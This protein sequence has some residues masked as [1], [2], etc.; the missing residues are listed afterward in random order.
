VTGRN[1]VTA[2]LIVGVTIAAYA[3]S[4]R[5]PFLWDDLSEIAD[6]PAIRMLLPFWRPMFT[7][8]ELP[9]R[10]V[11]YLTFALNHA[12]G[13]ML[14]AA[15]LQTDPL[16]TLPFHAVN[17]V[18]HLLN[19]WMLYCVVRDLLSRAPPVSPASGAHARTL[20]CLAV[21]LWLVHPLQ[22][23]AVSY[24]YQR[25]ELLASF[26]A[27]A[28]LAMFLKA[29]AASRP[30]PW[31]VVA[32]IA[33]GIGMACK[34][35]MVVV[36]LVVLL[37][38]RAFLAPSWR[39]AFARRG[40]WHAAL[41]ATIPLALVIVAVQRTRYP[42]A[43]F[44]AWQSFLYAVNQP[45]VILWYLSRLILPL[46]LS[47]DHGGVLRTEP[48]GRDAWLFAPAVLAVAA[49]AWAA[50]RLSRGPAA[51]FMILAFLLLLAPTSSVVPV[52]DPCVEHRMYLAAAI[53]ITAA[54]AA[55]GGRLIATGTSSHILA[56]G[57]PLVLVLAMITADRN[58][59]YC[60][61]VEVWQDAALKNGG[62]SRSLARL[63]SELSKL[64][65][66]AEALHACERAVQRNPSNPVPFAALAAALLNAERP[67]DAAAVCQA[68]LAAAA[69]TAAFTDPVRDRLSMYRGIALDR[70]GD[71]EAEPLLREA[72]ARRPDS[73]V[74]REHLARCLAQKSPR[75]SAA[76][77]AS[78]LAATPGDG[79][80]L[81][82]LGS[83]VARFDPGQAAKI[84]RA[85]VAADPENADACNNLG[86]VLLALGR[87][88]DAV[89]AFESCLRIDPTH[90]QAAANLNAITHPRSS[91][92]ALP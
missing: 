69:S 90:Q 21:S 71:P 68:G 52:L 6:N 70:L 87:R 16:D 54:V 50:F 24:I 67:A 27:L 32:T 12:L 2:A 62:S 29:A 88:D 77:W 72:V 82:H 86:G 37:A 59:V 81:F 11:P 64:D 73:L 20:A 41:F 19:G 43:G 18:I 53:P 48:F 44:T 45:A 13:R 5:G 38:D 47:L 91:A 74:A 34:E 65:R 1:R 31:L 49:A 33:C 76:L 25:I 30:L 35:W 10:P 14:V 3:P 46:G 89:R 60:S 42:E 85:A 80:L 92:P 7:G 8:G 15:G 39:E 83:A 23:Q 22:S 78:L 79:Y 57:I 63:G 28:T 84:L 61:A 36:P 55:V 26:S 75:E 58:S 17:V 51:S 40:G 4:L 9:H 66:H 56:A